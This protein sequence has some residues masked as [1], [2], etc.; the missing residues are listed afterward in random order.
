MTGAPPLVGPGP[1]VMV[2]DVAA[3]IDT[4]SA[5]LTGASG[6]VRMIAPLPTTDSSEWPY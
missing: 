1:Q 4:S 5:T 3:L 2:I 6:R